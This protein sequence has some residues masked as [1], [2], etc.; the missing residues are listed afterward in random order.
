MQSWRLVEVTHE[1]SPEEREQVTK[2]WEGWY[3]W[4][5]KSRLEKPWGGE[6]YG[7]WAAFI[8]SF[9]IG[10]SSYTISSRGQGILSQ[11]HTDPD[12]RR[13]GIARTTTHAV[14]E[15]FRKYGARAVYLAAWSD[16]IRDIYRKEGFVFAGAM[17]ERHAFKLTLADS[18]KDENLFRPGQRTLFRQLDI[19]DQC[20]LSS[21]FNSK[22]PLVVKHYDL[23]CYLGS[24]FEGEFYILRNQ[25]VTGI[26]AEEKGDKKGFRALVLDGEETIMGLG[27]VIPSSRRHEQHTGIIDI[28]LNPNYGEKMSELLDRLEE[29]CELDHLTVYLETHEEAKRKVFE[30]AGYRK[31]GELGSQ[32]KIGSE[33]YDLVA[34]RKN[35]KHG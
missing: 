8:G 7:F 20:D 15:S 35:L 25:K 12:F 9:C 6:K 4:S 2:F 34:Y 1:S 10:T 18:G 16:W 32:L 22:H 19:G 3:I 24:H 17:G 5:T 30:R 29:N 27:T 14:I 13:K 26:V 11:V 31:L 21:L 28:L 33:Y 23:G